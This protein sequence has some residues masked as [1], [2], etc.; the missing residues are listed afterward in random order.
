MPLKRLKSASLESAFRA[1]NTSSFAAKTDVGLPESA[2]IFSAA[3][4]AE[5]PSLVMKITGQS[6]SP[7]SKYFKESD[8][9]KT[10]VGV[11]RRSS[12][13]SAG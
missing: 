5:T 2:A 11:P 7:A 4:C 8:T 13:F 3:F 10:A 9:P 12:S 1:S 6:K